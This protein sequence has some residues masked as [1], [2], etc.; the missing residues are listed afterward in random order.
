MATT[1][2]IPSARATPVRPAAV[3]PR[4]VVARAAVGASVPDQNKR[5]IVNLMLV[6]AAALP[7]A[8]LA[9]PFLYF[10]APPRCALQH[11]CDAPRM[12]CAASC[13]SHARASA[14]T[15]DA[16]K[17]VTLRLQCALPSAERCFKLERKRSSSRLVLW[18]CIVP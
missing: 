6:G 4:S 18:A 13:M 9:G 7:T 15:S 11:Y 8:G 10:F 1:M 16:R 3:R 5:N 12:S 17:H 2:T 14:C